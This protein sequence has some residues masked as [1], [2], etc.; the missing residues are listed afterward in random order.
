MEQMKQIMIKGLC[1]KLENKLDEHK[2]NKYEYGKNRNKVIKLFLL[3]EKVKIN[4]KIYQ[5]IYKTSIQS[6]QLADQL[7][8]IFKK[9]LKHLRS[10]KEKA[11]ITKIQTIIISKNTLQI[12]KENKIFESCYKEKIKHLK[13]PTKT[14]LAIKR[15]IYFISITATCIFAGLAIKNLGTITWSLLNGSSV[16]ILKILGLTTPIFWLLISIFK[17]SASIENFTSKKVKKSVA[18]VN[19]QSRIYK[20][21]IAIITTLGILLGPI[22]IEIFK[23]SNIAL[24]L[25]AKT[26]I[27]AYPI[28]AAVA[29]C[30]LIAIM[31]INQ[32]RK[33][34]ENM[35]LAK[36]EEYTNII[37]NSKKFPHKSP[38]K[39]LSEILKTFSKNFEE[40]FEKLQIEQLSEEE[41]THINNKIKY[42]EKLN[43]KDEK[44]LLNKKRCLQNL[45]PI[46]GK[47][48]V[49]LSFVFGVLLGG[50]IGAYT[51]PSRIFQLGLNNVSLLFFGCMVAGVAI[52]SIAAFIIYLFMVKIKTLVISDSKENFES[53]SQIRNY[54]IKDLK[55]VLKRWGKIGKKQKTTKQKKKEIIVIEEIKEKPKS[56]KKK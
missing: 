14:S 28:L 46:V 10:K 11:Q 31:T 43:Q 42:I 8:L 33:A 32:R 9:D 50:G 23:F 3:F 21:S 56:K 30:F 24:S 47:V 2:N 49:I 27:I 19:K 55:Y 25:Y 26:I 51:L 37:L 45:F 39:H 20:A 12:L 54:I 15:V 6:D 34:L 13:T 40:E 4:Q 7:D 38:K 41:I 44:S 35:N 22:T 48:F 52:F 29:I 53:K 18:K 1:L 16:G 17:R 36:K 5:K